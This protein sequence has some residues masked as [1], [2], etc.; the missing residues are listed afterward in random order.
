M[1]ALKCEECKKSLPKENMFTAHKL[2]HI[3]IKYFPCTYVDCE[4]LFTARSYL[5]THYNSH[6]DNVI[7]HPTIFFRKR[8][9]SN[10]IITP[11][12]SLKDPES[13]EDK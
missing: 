5:N 1:Q 4:M 12:G 3:G 8:K 2:N 9:R 13:E 7:E 10:R 6:F 11:D